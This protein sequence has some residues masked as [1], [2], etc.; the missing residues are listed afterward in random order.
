MIFF[1]EPQPVAQPEPVAQP[2]PQAPEENE[3]IIQP[4]TA[5]NKEGTSSSSWLKPKIFEG[6]NLI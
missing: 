6:S 3:E 2:A 4:G 5:E 1:Q